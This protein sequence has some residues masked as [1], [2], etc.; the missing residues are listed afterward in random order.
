MKGQPDRAP[1]LKRKAKH[2][3]AL[4]CFPRVQSRSHSQDLSNALLQQVC[5][6]AKLLMGDVAQSLKPG[7][8]TALQVVLRP[9]T[10]GSLF[11]LDVLQQR[12]SPRKYHTPVLQALRL[13]DREPSCFD[14]ADLSDIALSA[15][16]ANFA[17]KA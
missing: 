15:S 2:A 17:G 8:S 10:S 6:C 4:Y 13:T 14:I 11:A 1:S 16:Q 5:Q 9:R 3:E 12:V 7:S